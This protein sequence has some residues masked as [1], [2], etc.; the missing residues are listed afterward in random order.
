[1]RYHL[2]K[3]LTLGGLTAALAVVIMCLLGMLGITTYVC[4]VLCMILLSVLVKLCS[5][6]ICWCWYVV[7]SVLSLLLAPDK[8][9]IA[10]FIFLGYYPILR[11]WMNQRKLSLIWK[12]FLFNCATILMYGLLLY[13][14][15]LAE[16]VS[17]MQEF[18]KFGAFILLVLGNMVF[19]LLDLV[20][21]R[22]DKRWSR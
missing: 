17:E 22:I 13:F 10:V 14:V 18:G 6:R 7:V 9:A 15:G 1:M 3:Q 16:L 20:L 2:T 11:P 4:P 19:F 12:L 5:T 8:E 21:V